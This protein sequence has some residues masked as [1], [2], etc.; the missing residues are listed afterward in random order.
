MIRFLKLSLKVTV[1]WVT[2]LGIKLKWLHYKLLRT[3]LNVRSV[4]IWKLLIK[5]TVWLDWLAFLKTTL[6]YSDIATIFLIT[7][8]K[9][10]ATWFRNTAIK[11]Q[12]DWK[13][14]KDRSAIHLSAIE[15]PG[16]GRGW[17]AP[18]AGAVDTHPVTC[19]GGHQWLKKHWLVRY[20]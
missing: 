3:V 15:G 14:C 19:I 2:G 6:P 17:E 5:V 11:L 1:L 8:L 12:C 4:K 18:A 7:T 9:H 10:S 16:E 13:H 20:R